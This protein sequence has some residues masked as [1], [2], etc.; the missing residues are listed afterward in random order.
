MNNTWDPDGVGVANGNFFGF[1]YSTKESQLVL[2]Q[3]PWDV[4][5]S[6]GSGTSEGPKAIVDA[7]TQLDFFRFDFP[8]A[9]ENKIGSLPV[10]PWIRDTSNI[11]RAKA[12][13]IIDRLEQGE[14][15]DNS[16]IQEVNK[17]CSLLIERVEEQ[18]NHWLDQG[19][20]VG[21]VG[22][23]HSTPLGLFKAIDSHHNEWGILQIDAHMDLREA[24]EGF[25]HSHA[26]IMFNTLQ[27]TSVNKI[28]QVGIRDLCQAEFD[29]AKSTDRLVVFDDIKIKKNLLS[30][31][32]WKAWAEKIVLSL[33]K[34]VY[35][36]FDID[37]LQPELC[38]N[39]GTPVPG[40]LSFEMIL[41]LLEE[42]RVQ[43]KKIIGF[44]LVEVCP[45]ESGDWDANVGAR[46]LYELC[47]NTLHCHG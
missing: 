20:I 17:A 4:T 40:G 6:Y 16:L 9:W 29:L 35:I 2:M 31:G 45:G 30:G 38:P 33:P 43:K 12:K 37:G 24:Y 39:T 14:T 27:E 8:N 21:L 1:P 10:D 7:S 19:K 5:T 26:S 46:I 11:N 42:I 18:A 32:N 36:S 28:V 47:Q 13:S 41:V 44:D 22:G 23:D 15:P 25:T 34:N 3:V